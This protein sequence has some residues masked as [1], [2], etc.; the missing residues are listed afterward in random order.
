LFI[1]VF[2]ITC[3]FCQQKNNWIEKFDSNFYGSNA[4]YTFNYERY[5]KYSKSQDGIKFIPFSYGIN[6][7]NIMYKDTGDIKYLESNKKLVDNLISTA[8][9]LPRSWDKDK[10]KKYKGWVVKREAPKHVIGKDWQLYE[11]Y[12]YRYVA[13]YLYILKEK[14]IIN[15]Y[16]EIFRE[17][18]QKALEFLENQVWNKWEERSLLK[19]G[20]MAS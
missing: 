19:N 18:Y 1:N 2:F 6:A 16:P 7:L 12:I 10:N 5:L 11:G 14:E 20:N 8:I 17:H 13:Q 3:G 4:D 15:T 9:P